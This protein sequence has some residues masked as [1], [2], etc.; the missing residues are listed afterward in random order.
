MS[1]VNVTIPTIHLNGSSAEHMLGD[2]RSARTAIRSAVE[3]VQQ[4]APN[5][6]DYYVMLPGA[7]E[8]ALHEHRERLAALKKIDDELLAIAMGIMDQRRGERG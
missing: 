7:Y 8:R 4:T 3:A 1:E 6:R 2:Y 5:G